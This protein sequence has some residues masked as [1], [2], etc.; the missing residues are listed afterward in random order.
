MIKIHPYQYAYF[1]FL[2]GKDFNKKFEMDY[3]GLSYKENI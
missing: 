2:A 1:N 3:W